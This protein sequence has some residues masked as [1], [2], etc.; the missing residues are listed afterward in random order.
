MGENLHIKSPDCPSSVS[1]WK[2]MAW[3]QH[4]N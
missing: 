2:V 4:I 3:K 1:G